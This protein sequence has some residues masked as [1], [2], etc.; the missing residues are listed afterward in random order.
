MS[1]PTSAKMEELISSISTKVDIPEVVTQ[2]RTSAP[3]QN[4]MKFNIS[5]K[6]SPYI[7]M[8]QNHLIAMYIIVTLIGAYM[9]AQ[10]REEDIKSSTEKKKPSAMKVLVWSI[11]FNIPLIIWKAVS[12]RKQA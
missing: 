10:S 12:V 11:V 4:I 2:E 8:Y 1:S 3:S 7:S 5:E 6:V 9:F